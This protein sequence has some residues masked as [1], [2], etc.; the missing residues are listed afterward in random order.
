MVDYDNYVDLL[1]EKDNEAFQVIYENTRKGVF[2]MIIS[3][4]GN[5]AATEDLMQDTY[6]K[7]IEKIHQYKRGRNFY[8][9]LLQIAKNTALDYYRK[10]KRMNVYDPQE[11]EYMFDSEYTETDD[12]AVLDMVKSLDE[13]EKQIV[14]LRV[15]SDMKFK[16]IAK[17]IAKPLGTV[18]W[19]YNKAIKKL[20]DETIGKE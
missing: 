3:I 12:Y 6:M 14:L 11:K 4:V 10:E 16:D 8:A 9:W 5:K 13:E 2:S 15:V 19:I 20:Q 1:I 7:M 18:L 17:A